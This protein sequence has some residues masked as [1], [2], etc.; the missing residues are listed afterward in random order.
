MKIL[1]I[2]FESAKPARTKHLHRKRKLCTLIVG[3]VHL[4]RSMEKRIVP[5]EVHPIY[6]LREV[7]AENYLPISMTPP[8]IARLS[9]LEV[10]IPKA[11]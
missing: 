6:A 2:V 7:L 1:S 5:R 9:G 11:M 10:V 8:I 3:D 4:Y